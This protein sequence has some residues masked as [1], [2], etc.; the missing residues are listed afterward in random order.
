LIYR[1]KLFAALLEA[2]VPSGQQESDFCVLLIRHWCQLPDSLRS[3][4]KAE[5]MLRDFATAII[6]GEV[7]TKSIDA[8]SPLLLTGGEVELQEGIKIRTVNDSELWEYGSEDLR[9]RWDPTPN[10]LPFD[11]WAILEIE[12]VHPI[13]QQANEIQ[14]I[15]GAVVAALVLS[16]AKTFRFIPLGMT[17]SYG[18]FSMG[19][20]YLGSRDPQAFGNPPWEMSEV[21]TEKIDKIV[22][23]GEKLY[24]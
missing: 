4:E 12:I 3:P 18:S 22:K 16:G 13:G 21:E 5:P 1:K 8:F 14:A 6:N 7:V 24:Q 2:G 11:N 23:G 19:R 20:Q 15:R 10:L 17:K 9:P